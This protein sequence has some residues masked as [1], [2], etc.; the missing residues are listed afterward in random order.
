MEVGILSQARI[1]GGDG[2]E[3]AGADRHPG[4]W[5]DDAAVALTTD[6]CAERREGSV[7][8]ERGVE[9]GGFLPRISLESQSPGIRGRRIAIPHRAAERSPLGRWDAAE[10]RRTLSL[11]IDDEAA[12]DDL[13]IAF[14]GGVSR[15]ST[16]DSWPDIAAS[17]R[18][19][20]DDLADADGLPV[21]LAV[22]RTAQTLATAPESLRDVTVPVGEAVFDLA[23][24]ESWD[25]AASILR[26]ARRRLVR[27]RTGRGPN[28]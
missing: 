22:S 26:D 13:S 12:L 8:P 11:R 18:Y 7:E 19:L 23:T 14:S 16:R 17:L 28:V 2:G 20:L 24:A 1:E 6:P 27:R 25:S 3:R 5:L 9:S 4:V 21:P 15:P 10:E